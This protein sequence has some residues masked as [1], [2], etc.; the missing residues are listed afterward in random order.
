MGGASRLTS[1][2][3]RRM[4]E[5]A[6]RVVGADRALFEHDRAARPRTNERVKQEA[7]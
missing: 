3:P 2:F 7:E 6:G 1:L 4:V 5:A